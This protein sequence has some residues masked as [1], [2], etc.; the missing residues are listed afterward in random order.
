MYPYIEARNIII[1]STYYT[2]VLHQ[3]TYRMF[4]ILRHSH[5]Q[6][7]KINRDIKSITYSRTTFTQ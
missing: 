6:F 7:Q 1:Y 4:E 5:T 2:Y 3:S